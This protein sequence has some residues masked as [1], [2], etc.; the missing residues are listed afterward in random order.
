M[1]IRTIAD[2]FFKAVARN[3]DRVML[4]RQ[5]VGWVPI[6]SQEMYR[7]VAGVVRLLASW[8]IGPGDRVALLSEN[9]PEWAIADFATQLLGAAVVPIYATL[10]GEQTGYILRDSGARVLFVSSRSQFDKASAILSQTAVEKMVVMDDVET[11][12]AVRMDRVMRDGATSADREL[13]ARGRRVQQDDVATIIYTSG[14]T[15]RPKGVMLT[16]R[17]L[18]SNILCAEEGFD[19]KPGEAAISFLPLSHV[20]A[21]HVDYILFHRGVTLAY[22]PFIERLPQALLEIQPAVFVGVPRVY[23][24]I[25]AQVEAQAEKWPK[26]GI[27]QWALSVGRAHKS[28]ILAGTEPSSLAWKLA[29]KLVFSKIRHGMGGKARVFVSGGAPLGRE[30]ADWYATVG[31]RIHEGYGLTE[32]S[33][34]IA[35]NRPGVHKIGTVGKPLRNVEVRIAPDGEILVRGPSVFRQ[36][37]NRP[38]ETSEAFVDGFFK[39]GDVGN[40]DEDGFLSVTD[41]KKDLIKTSGGKFIAPQPIENSLK[42]NA[43][44]GAAIVV[45]EKRK[46][47]CVL[48]APYFPLL[49]SWAQNNEVLCSSREELV[50]HAKVRALYEGIVENLNQSLARFERLKKVILVADEF[51]VA[52]GTLTPSLKLRRRAIE[53][54]YQAMIDDVYA[55]A[56]QTA[57]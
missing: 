11:A 30:L 17:N 29:N 22:C 18:T 13:D 27:Y 38:E 45:G 15:G 48:I 57:R 16:H 19:F 6:S 3:H 5:A 33:P 52:D 43:L 54:R 50:G 40:V 53:E 28:E 8:G 49:Q 9:R 46:F 44:I 14:T 26:R 4:V 7:D 37:W 23:E 36:Y 10:T 25:Y 20:T 34:V 35:V 42:L 32:T 31:I 47:P 21:R 51:S 41:R 24:K 39:T 12:H 55:K 2:I 1:E 56:E